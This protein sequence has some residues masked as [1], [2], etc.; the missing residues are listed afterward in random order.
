MKCHSKQ[1]QFF[2]MC[3]PYRELQ[4]LS[5]R[6]IY[7]IEQPSIQTCLLGLFHKNTRKKKSMGTISDF[8][9][10]NAKVTQGFPVPRKRC[11]IVTTKRPVFCLQNPRFGLSCDPKHGC[12]LKTPAVGARL[13]VP[14]KDADC[15]ISQEWV[16]RYRRVVAT[17]MW[18]GECKQV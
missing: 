9:Q 1:Q 7:Q 18:G 8:W 12:V 13:R 4:S 10:N 14:M 17:V 16:Q 6:P 5:S 11:R 3:C 15:R 2:Q